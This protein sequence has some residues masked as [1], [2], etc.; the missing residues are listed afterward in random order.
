[1][2]EAVEDQIADAIVAMLT[3]APGGTFSQTI[4]DF[5]KSYAP[6]KDAS[7]GE[8]TERHV[9]VTPGEQDWSLL[10]RGRAMQVDYTMLVQYGL[11]LGEVTSANV[12]AETKVLQEIALY[13][14]RNHL[15]SRRE[16]ALPKFILSYDP[17]RLK[18]HGVYVGAVTLTYRGSQ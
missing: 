7:V 1:M 18:Q 5:A 2:P 15:P 4:A 16:T 10:T 13:L 17:D 8:L 12:R 11:R 3:A 6:Q 9:L 14:L